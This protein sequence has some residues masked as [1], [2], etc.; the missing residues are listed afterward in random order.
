MAKPIYVG[1]A[2]VGLDI[3]EMTEMATTVDNTNC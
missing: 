3:D 1:S 2:I